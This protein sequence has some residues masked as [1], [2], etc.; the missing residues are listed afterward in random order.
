MNRASVIQTCDFSLDT[1]EAAQAKLAKAGMTP[2]QHAQAAQRVSSR[3]QLL[4]EAKLAPAPAV[5]VVSTEPLVVSVKSVK[6]DSDGGRVFVTASVKQQL[7]CSLCSNRRWD[8]QHVLD[9]ASHIRAHFPDTRFRLHHVPS[10]PPAEASEDDPPAVELLPDEPAG[11]RL[12]FQPIPL[13]FDPPAAYGSDLRPTVPEGCKCP[14][15]SCV[16]EARCCIC[17]SHWDKSPV[18]DRKV[19]LR[20]SRFCVACAAWYTVGFFFPCRSRSTK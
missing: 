5:W 13:T 15:S 2:C 19:W 7:K 10:H 16:C 12:R 11:E 14:L 17:G 6:H 20:R 8:C 4:Q 1:F 3:F 9:A 18:A